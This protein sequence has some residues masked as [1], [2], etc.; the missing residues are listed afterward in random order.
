MSTIPSDKHSNE[1]FTL[2]LVLIRIRLA[3]VFIHTVRGL[4]GGLLQFSSTKLL[5][6]FLA[7]V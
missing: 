7:S 3:G 2:P 6:I 1:N 5:K 4:T